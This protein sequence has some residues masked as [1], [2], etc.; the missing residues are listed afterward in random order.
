MNRRLPQI[1][2]RGTHRNP[3][4]RFEPLALEA[5]AGDPWEPEEGWDPEG[6]GAGPRPTRIFRDPARTILTR[7]L[8]PDVGFDWS[9]NPYRGCEHGCV[10][11]YARPT[12]EYLGFSAGLDF[13]SRILARTGAADLL[14]KELASPRW[15]PQTIV[16]SGVTDPYQPVEG[17]L[18]ITRACLEVM[19]ECRHPVAVI[20][21]SHRV[22]R[23]LD[24]LRTLAEVGAAHVTV[25][26][27]TLDRS[28]QRALEPRASS[29]RRRLE[30]IQGLADAGIPVAVNVAPI[31][32]GLTDHEIPALLEAGAEAGA[33]SAG[34]VLL[35]L[36]HGVKE[37]FVAWL[38]EHAPDRAGKVLGRIRDTRDGVL[39][40]SPFGER[41]KGTGPYARQMEQLFK[42][43]ARRYGLAK[44]SLGL[45]TGAFR[46]PEAP[47]GSSSGTSGRDGPAQLELRFTPEQG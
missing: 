18:G 33:R 21:K 42:V 41:M 4:G 45:S 2:S 35:R 24:L 29:P 28:L 20:T 5:V 25:S 12:H 11:C 16:M 34:F 40:R 23:D 10:Y 37:L 9:L 44:R 36:P 26:L 30:A 6:T 22:L 14:R 47:R 38:A 13:E 3:T 8:S 19:A 39:Y 27:T 31:I 1:R 43:S 17:R 32:P 15:E 7:N 46:R